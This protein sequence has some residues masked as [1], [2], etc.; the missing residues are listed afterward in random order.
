MPAPPLH[1]VRRLSYS[2]LALFE[3]CSYRYYAERVAG[4]R[5]RRGAGAGGESGSPRPR[6][7]TRCTACSSWS[8]WRDPRRPTSRSCATWYPAVTEEELERIGAFVG[9]Y[10]ESELARRVAAL[11]G[12]RPERPFAFEHDGVLLHGRLDVLHRDGPRAL[13]VDYKTNVLGERTPEEIV[14]A[15]YRLQRLVYALA[16]FRAGAEE[17]EVVYA[18]LERPDAVV[19]TT[20]ARAECRRSR[21]SCR[22]RSRRI[23]AGEFVPTPERVHLPR[24]PGARRRLRRPAPGRR[25][26]RGTR[27]SRGR[28]SPDDDRAGSVILRA[29]LNPTLSQTRLAFCLVLATAF[30]VTAVASGAKRPTYMWTQPA[31]WGDPSYRATGDGLELWRPLVR[32]G[33]GVDETGDLFVRFSRMQWRGWGTSTAVATGLLEDCYA[34]G[35]KCEKPVHVRLVLSRP[36]R[37]TCGERASAGGTLVYTQYQLSGYRPLAGIEAF[38]AHLLTGFAARRIR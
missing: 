15:D 28:R 25:A 16:C 26:R 17:V 9:A 18:F 35:P 21:P 19:S 22:T 5:E 24:L 4:L 38:D 13:V 6:S 3:R 33:V 20:F 23:N 31:P 10:C 11:G 7:A 12:A 32:W 1:R 29:P 30:A 36:R 8:T 14:E 27:R 2:A 37:M 34:E